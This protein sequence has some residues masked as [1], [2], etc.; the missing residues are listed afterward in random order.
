MLLPPA[1]AAATAAARPLQCCSSPAA[2]SPLPHAAASVSVPSGL[3]LDVNARPRCHPPGHFICALTC[4]TLVREPQGIKNEEAFGPLSSC[5]PYSLPGLFNSLPPFPF[6][7][8]CLQ[9]IK[10]EEAFGPLTP[11]RELFNGRAAMVGFAA[12]LLVEAFR[13][14]A[15]F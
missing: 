8:N 13:G 10:N 4:D 15:L 6:P 7:L 1:A 2:P 14:T 5:L 9:G 3:L 12:L 11:E